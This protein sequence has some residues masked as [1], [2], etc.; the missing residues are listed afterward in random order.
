MKRIFSLIVAMLTFIMLFTACGN[1]T[2]EC[3]YFI[4]KSYTF[5]SS[6]EQYENFKFDVVYSD[7]EKDD[8]GIIIAQN[9]EAGKKIDRNSKITL[10][11]SLGKK[12]A[13]VPDVKGLSID[14]AKVMI[15]QAGFVPEIVYRTHDEIEENLCYGTTPNIGEQAAIGSKVSVCISLGAKKNFI[16]IVNFVGMTEQQGVAKILEMGLNV[17]RITYEDSEKQSGTIIEQYPDYAKSLEIAEG[18]LI[19]LII[20]K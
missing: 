9:I 12:K 17:G 3:P 6:A 18:S 1:D 11:V 20:A 10:T 5:V 16:E 7:S 13:T 19:N 2:T 4:G 15:E 8:D 14:A